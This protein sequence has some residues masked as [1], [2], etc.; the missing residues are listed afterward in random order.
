MIKLGGLRDSVTTLPFSAIAL[1][2]LEGLRRSLF[3]ERGF[4][5]WNL[6]RDIC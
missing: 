2:N 6:V 3:V 4:I 1:G 5:S